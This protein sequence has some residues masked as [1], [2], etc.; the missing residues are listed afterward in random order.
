MGLLGKLESFGKAVWDTGNEVVDVLGDA[1]TVVE[2]AQAIAGFIERVGKSNHLDDLIEV[3]E[4]LGG[5]AERVGTNRFLRAADSPILDAGQLVIAGMKLTTGIG[6]PEHGER[7]G[8]GG[9]RFHEAGATLRSAQ[10]TASWSGEGA[11]SYA[12]QNV[13]QAERTEGIAAGDHEVHR[14]L[15]AEAFQVAFHR[16]RLDD[17]NDFLA[18]V[19]LVTFALGLIPGVGQEWKAVAEAQAVLAAVGSS[20]LE[21]YQ[22]SSEAGA[23]AEEIRQVVGRYE[24][25]EQTANLSPT[26]ANPDPLPPPPPQAPPEQPPIDGPSEEKPGNVPTTPPSPA[27][28]PMPSSLGRSVPAMPTAGGSGSGAGAGSPAKAG[29]P[30]ASPAEVP[31]PA[32]VPTQTAADGSGAPPSAGALPGVLS[33]MLPAPTSA[34]AAP[35]GASGVPV[36]LIK[37]AVEAAM[38]REAEKRAGAGEPNDEANQDRDGKPRRRKRTR[39][40]TAGPA[41]KRTGGTRRASRWRPP[42]A[43]TG[44]ARP[45][46]SSW[47]STGSN[48]PRRRRLRWLSK[49]P[50]GRRR[51]QQRRKI[52]RKGDMSGDLRVTTAHLRELAAKQRQAAAEMR[53]ATEVVDGVDTSVRMTHGVIAWST[54]AAVEAVQNARRTAGTRVKEVSDEMADKLDASAAAYDRIDEVAGVRLYGQM[55]PR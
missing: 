27:P 26:G 55:R 42:V 29:L 2:G 17:W 22:L 39:A 52:R 40:R 15:A 37:E 21:L 16:D 43:S 30:A 24:D 32:Q 18:D 53:S 31:E 5:W 3:G 49:N 1:A 41:R 25:V 12:V 19:G 54:A 33:G 45:C 13:K 23:N 36:A 6:E 47:T 48:C 51:R 46:T 44:A 8:G 28:M 7:F 35:S 9:A 50:S 38:Q 11:D 4:R 10:P 14:V 34:G 20:S